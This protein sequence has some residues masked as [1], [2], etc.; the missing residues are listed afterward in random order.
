MY[1]RCSNGSVIS[2]Q[3]CKH[4]GHRSISLINLLWL[5]SQ[6]QK[7]MHRALFSLGFLFF[8]MALWCLPTY[9]CF[10]FS[11]NLTS[12]LKCRHLRLTSL[13]LCLS[14]ATRSRENGPSCIFHGLNVLFSMKDAA[15]RHLTC[16]TQCLKLYTT[17][18][19]ELQCLFQSNS[20]C[21]RPVLKRK[22]CINHKFTST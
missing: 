6:R 21:F 13:M 15:T 20:P 14:V 5:C 8:S 11:G 17:Q 3:P 16:Q 12:H 10:D 18:S 22:C 19:E 2:F 7:Q 4:T 9:S 1:L